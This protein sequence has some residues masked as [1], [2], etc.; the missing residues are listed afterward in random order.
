MLLKQG[1]QQS[2][3]CIVFTIMKII[4]FADFHGSLS[5]LKKAQE[6]VL[7]EKPQKTVLCG[8]LFGGWSCNP[9][10][11]DEI[12][13]SMDTI[14]YVLRGNNDFSEYESQLSQ[15]MEENAVMYHF[16][17]TLFFTHGHVYNASHL[18]SFL[19]QNDVLVHGHTHIGFIRNFNGL[20]IANVGSMALPRDGQAN[21]LV[22]DDD[23]IT[24]KATDGTIL[25][26]IFW[27]FSQK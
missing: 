4:A 5:A 12:L 10:R 25:Q 2:R 9:K 11:I 23:G 17:R 22:L 14:L 20:T 15:P 21:Y 8:D 19:G 7:K 13:Q 1:R 26:K 16:S 3:P 27:T 18:P 6:I 24:L